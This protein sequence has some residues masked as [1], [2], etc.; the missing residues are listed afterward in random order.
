MPL[1]IIK[2]K[3]QKNANSDYFI[4]RSKAISYTALA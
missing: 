3:M 2:Y 4:L 1:S